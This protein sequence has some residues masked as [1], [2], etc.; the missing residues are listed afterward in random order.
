MSEYIA[1]QVIL[2]RPLKFGFNAQTAA[3]NSFQE[4]PKDGFDPGVTQEKALLE[5]SALAENLSDLGIDVLIFDDT[6]APHTPD[7]IFPNNWFSTHPDGT[8]CLYPMQAE[9]RRAERRNEIITTLENGFDVGRVIDLTGFETEGKFLEGTG[10]LVL[11]HQNRI[12]YACLSPRTNKDLLALWTEKTN[13]S[14][15]SFAAFDFAGQAI[16]H[17]N[18]LMCVGG[19]FAVVCLESVRD[20][21]ERKSLRDSLSGAGLSVVEISLEQMRNF[22]GNMLQLF[23]KTGESILL[24]SL[25]AFDSLRPLQI[26]TLSKYARLVPVDISTI[27]HVGGGSVRCMIA[28]NFLKQ[29][30]ATEGHR[31]C[32]VAIQHSELLTKDLSSASVSLSL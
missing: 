29:K 19:G 24:M 28:E 22:A 13:F 5:F 10:S 9:N 23:T 26:E 25:R 11:D 14:V 30:I 12:A 1:H 31:E 21:G 18:V 7:S 16:Y 20:A 15:V 4:I 17:T 32:K 8:L 3:S 6:P 2:I 27:E